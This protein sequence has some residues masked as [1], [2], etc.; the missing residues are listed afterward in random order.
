[1]VHLFVVVQLD[2]KF[3]PPVAEIVGDF[4]LLKSQYIVKMDCFVASVNVALIS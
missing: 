4:S 3:T 2:N 1:M